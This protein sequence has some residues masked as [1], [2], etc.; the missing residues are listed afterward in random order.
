M[1]SKRFIG[2]FSIV[3][4]LS[5]CI[6]VNADMVLRANGSGSITLEYH[7][8]QFLESLG[9]LDGNE[10]WPLIPVGRADFERSVQRI[11]GLKLVSFASRKREADIVY[12]VKLEF[13][14]LDALVRFLDATGNRAVLT[15]EAGT[16]RLSLTLSSGQDI[17]PDLLSLFASVSQPYS[18]AISLSAPNNADLSVSGDIAGASIVP[19]GRKVSFSA[20]LPAL[21]KQNAGAIVDIQWQ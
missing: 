13:S 15:Q 8:S 10:N 18:I 21:L 9:K 6:G 3:M 14:G 19:S 7:V 1:I 16:T 17:D 12:T 4:L 5:S 2:M 20:P 11:E